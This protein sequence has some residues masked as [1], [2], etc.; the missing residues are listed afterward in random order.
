MDSTRIVTASGFGESRRT[1]TRRLYQYDYGQ[2]LRFDLELP[3][4]Y[5]VHFALTEYCGTSITQIGNADGVNIPDSL[6]TEGKKIYAW[7]YLHDGAD[8]GETRYTVEIPVAAR[9]EI[10]NQE[11]AP[12]QQDAITEAIAA[13]NVAVEQTAQDAESASASASSAAQSAADAE[14]SAQISENNAQESERQAG[15]SAN[16]AD[17]SARHAQT[18][19]QSAQ[20]SAASASASAAN[21]EDAAESADRA[22]QVAATNGWMFFEI[23]GGDLWMERTPNV[24]TDF[25]LQDGDLWMEAIG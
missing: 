12:V 2:V 21:A 16:S 7:V 13:L 11:P 22:E 19:V 5:E 20:E 15:L 10:T 8:D 17:E 14:T 23:V 6:L 4:A 25:Y 18:S 3:Q 1:V 24:D 9:P